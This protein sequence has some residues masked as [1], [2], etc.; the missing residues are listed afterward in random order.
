MVPSLQL[1][2]PEGALRYCRAGEQGDVVAD[3]FEI[4]RPVGSGGMGRV[5]CALDRLSG[6]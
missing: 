5:Y 6:R 2:G 1:G 4:E 3:R